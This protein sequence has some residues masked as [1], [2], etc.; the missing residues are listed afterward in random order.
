MERTIVG[1]DVGTTKVCTLVGQVGDAGTLRVIGVGVVPSRGLR[2]GVITDVE[3]A[4]KAIGESIRKAERVSGLTITDAY[5]GVGGS[6]IASQNSRGL[7]AIGKGD[8]PIDRD[9]IDRAMEAALAIA[10]PHNRRIIHS[11]AREFIIDGQDGVRNPLGLMGFRLE[12]EAHIVTGAVTSIQNLVRC[13]EMNQ[14]EINDLVLQPLASA[15]AVLT[16]EERNIGVAL[17]DMGGG[18]TDLAIYVEGSI[19]DTQVFAVGGNHLTNDVA[20]GL[21]APLATAEDIKIRYA[22]AVPTTVDE[23]EMIEIATFGDENLRTISRRELCEIVSVRAEEMFELIAREIKRSGFDGLLPAG[24]VITGGTAS[25]PGLRD[26]AAGTLSLPVRIGMPRRLQ[27]LVETIS[28]PAYAT[29]VG[30]LLWGLEQQSTTVEIGH[31]AAAGEEWYE[32]VRR[33]LRVFLPG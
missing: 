19:W 11:I 29:S 12:V 10:V 25:L 26:L 8:R 27:G 24:V 30:L 33:W 5:V 18:T 4:A 1:I 13:V 15:E 32:R 14:I 21:R 22:H 16:E 23:H 17:I 3:E 28:S 9:D 31:R 7:A 20:V 6:H 2:K